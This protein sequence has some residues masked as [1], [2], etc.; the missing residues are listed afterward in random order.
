MSSASPIEPPGPIAFLGLGRMGMPMATR[1]LAAGWELR[2]FDL[3]ADR[4][5]HFATAD[6]ASAP[7]DPVA[8]V[9]GAHAAILML[10]NSAAVAA[11][12]TQ[13]GVLS[14]MTPGGLVIDMGSSEPL[15]TQKLGQRAADHGVGVLDAP[16]SGGVSGAQT[17]TLT[18]MVGGRES[19]FARA[20]DLLG[21]LGR[22]VLH[23]GPI[24]A[25]HAL[26]ALN[27]LLSATHLLASA[28]V[29]QI[30]RAFGLR[31]ETML[32]VINGSSGRSASTEAKLPKFILPGTYDSGFDLALM[33]KDMRIAVDLARGLEQRAGLAD[34][35]VT[36]WEEAA[37]E[38]PPTAD[39]TE[40]ALW[41][42]RSGGEAGE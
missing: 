40:I 14:S 31:P 12:I 27:N 7:D 13:T 16:V 34:A 28:E 42:A 29:L 37:A 10:P 26:K 8:T 9:V 36:L 20:A 30:G 39:H 5:E 17:G 6:G 38:L 19:D 25:G 18:V 1:L 24:G 35:A 3:D 11:A 33:L 4:R 21:V 22:S 41:V 2:G 15:H 32:E 23:V